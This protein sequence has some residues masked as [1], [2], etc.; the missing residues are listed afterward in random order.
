M[1][2]RVL[3]LSSAKPGTCTGK[4]SVTTSD[5][6]Q[7]EMMNCC[8]TTAKNEGAGAVRWTARRSG[9]ALVGT[10]G[11]SL[12]PSVI[13]KFIQRIMTEFRVTR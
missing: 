11:R 9:Y 4:S 13:V 6:S 1:P 12:V 7:L 2:S 5:C 10:S 3:E 8:M